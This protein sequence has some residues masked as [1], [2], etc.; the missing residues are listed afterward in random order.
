ML[1]ALRHP[2]VIGGDNEERQIDRADASNHVAHEILVPGNVD[3]SGMNS[4]GQIQLGETEV[5][6]DLARFLFGQPVGIGPGKRFDQSAL[7]VID[8]TSR[9]ND[10]MARNHIALCHHEGHEEREELQDKAFDPILQLR[11][12]E[13]DQ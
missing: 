3:N 9:G 11:D 5:D 1:L 10:E 6:R 4:A 13:I 8:V 2:A 12:V 7:A